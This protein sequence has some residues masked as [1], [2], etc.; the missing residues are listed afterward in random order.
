MSRFCVRNITFNKDRVIVN[1]YTEFQSNSDFVH[2]LLDLKP[3]LLN[4]VC[5]SSKNLSE[6]SL[7]HIFEHLV[8]DYQRSGI[9]T[10]TPVANNKYRVELTYKDDIECLEAINKSRNLIEELLDTS[11]SLQ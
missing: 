1:I 9:G 4:H 6:T 8:I 11:S 3:N 5:R 7:A 2:Q 10:T